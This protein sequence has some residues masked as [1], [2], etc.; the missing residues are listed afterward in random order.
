M[1]QG[2]CKKA[3]VFWVNKYFTSIH[4]G[5][6]VGRDDP[7]YVKK[8]A[9]ELKSWKRETQAGCAYPASNQEYQYMLNRQNQQNQNRRMNAQIRAQ[10]Q[11][12]RTESY[13]RT[14]D[15]L[16]AQN[17]QRNYN[18]QQTLDRMITPNKSTDSI[19]NPSNNKFYIHSDGTST[20]KVGNTYYHSNGTTT[21][22][23]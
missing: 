4:R 17:A 3:A 2:V 18:T 21:T 23:Y 19:I 14:M 20:R 15:R 13:Q 12:A 5:A 9:K 16:Q 6:K 10:Q 7:D 22:A 8:Y 11:Q 1:R